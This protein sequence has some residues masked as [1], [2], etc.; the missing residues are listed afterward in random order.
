MKLDKLSN[1]LKKFSKFKNKS[2]NKKI[3]FDI[4]G[5]EVPGYIY[6]NILFLVTMNKLG[7]NVDYQ[8]GQNQNN[9]KEV[10]SFNSDNFFILFPQ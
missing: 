5:A 7:Y 8:I 2:S 10:Y 9:L 6:N 4:L 3:F 1:Y